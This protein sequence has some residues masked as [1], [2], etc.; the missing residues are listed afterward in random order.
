MVSFKALFGSIPSTAETEA[1]RAALQREYEAFLEFSKSKELSEFLKLENEVTSAEFAQRKKE[2]MAQKF[3]DTE[4]YRKEQEY[5][6]RKKEKDI[7]NYYRIKES[8]ELKELHAFEESD[9]L[10]RYHELE[11]FIKSPE[12]NE[13]KSYMALSPKRKFESSELYKTLGQYIEQKSSPKIKNYFK[14]INSKEYSD[15][16]NLYK[17]KRL[18]DFEELRD[19]IKSGE[20]LSARRSKKKSDFKFTEEYQKLQQYEG[21]KKSKE[22]KNYFKLAKSPRLID[23][24]ELHDSQ[25]LEAYIELEK[26][27]NSPEYKSEKNSIEGQKFEDTDEYKKLQEYKSLKNSK[28]FKDNFKFKASKLYANYVNL[29][30]TERIKQVEEL[31]KFIQS[32]KF[33]EVKEYMLLPPAKKL[34]LS[35]EY[36]LEQKYIE[37]KNSEKIVWYFELKDS[38][39]FD[40]LKNWEVTF[41]EDFST[42]KLD[43]EKWMTRYYW[44]DSLLKDSYSL[45]HEKHFFTDGENL[46]F[47]NG[48]LRILTKKEKTRGKAWDPQYGFYTKDFDYTSGLISTA[49]SF[50]QKYG[51]F[52]AKIRFNESLPVNHSF[53]M[54]SDQ[55]LPHID[56]AKAENKLIMSSFWGSISERRGIRKKISK[57]SLS[58]FSGDFYIYSLEWSQDKLVW[59]INGVEVTSSKQGVPQESMYL[60][61]SSGIYKDIKGN[62]LPAAM[63]IDW[64]R[65]YKRV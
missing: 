25:E 56:I 59:K 20:F 55:V 13:V 42:G 28:K 9:D 23:Y 5:L 14:F 7:K 49:N 39:K 29:D 16:K 54:L 22:F 47:D 63:E 46:E 18:K 58:K 57:L 32:D 26:Y 37:L 30:G 53:W 33:M 64:V 24:N 43:R 11:E 8:D 44:G 61:L 62:N 31:E 45:A 3:K 36:K 6:S 52:E 38:T 51:L 15:F 41:E 19:F 10:K 27:I 60:I 21:L 48:I 65:C 35:E 50:R 34:E 12:Y 1:K 40:E 4:E 17:S 2:I